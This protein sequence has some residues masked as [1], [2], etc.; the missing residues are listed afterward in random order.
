MTFDV[1]TLT[2]AEGVVS[3]AGG[4]ILLMNWWLDRTVWAAFWWGTANC[5]AGIG[6]A[7]LALH[8]VLPA[9]ASY[10][11]GPL[12]LDVCA[13]LAWSAAWIFNRGS[14]KLY[15]VLA[16][17]GAGIALLIFTAAYASQQFAVALGWGISGC[18]YAA[19]A[20][21]FWLARSE[22]LR[23]RW[24]MISLLGLMAI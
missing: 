18:L 2:F 3:F 8:A 14:I 6:I 17:V 5:G 7:M 22:K 13:A 24:P 21:E 19:G 12:V 4:L 15:P 11:V 23:G 20:I 10:F 16:A 1:S 9:Y